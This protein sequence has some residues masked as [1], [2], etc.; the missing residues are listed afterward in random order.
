MSIHSFGSKQC[1]KINLKDYIYFKT[2]R[3]LI[4]EVWPP[5]TASV[6][7][8]LVAVSELSPRTAGHILVR[9]LHCCVHTKHLHFAGG[10]LQ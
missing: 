4:L 2:T 7:V 3:I 6:P 9:V 10:A 8:R 5:E 1:T